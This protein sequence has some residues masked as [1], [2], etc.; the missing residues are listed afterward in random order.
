[1]SSERAAHGDEVLRRV[2]GEYLE[3]P[4]LRLTLAQ[5]CRLWGLDAASCTSLLATLVDA[6]FLF[7][8]RDGAFMRVEYATAVKAALVPRKGLSA[9]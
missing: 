8:T 2:K 1:M 9:A 4:G 7:R 3:M 5:A 6:N